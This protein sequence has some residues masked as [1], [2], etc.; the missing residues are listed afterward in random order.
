MED[1]QSHDYFG[2]RAA[3]ERAAAERAADE[4]AAHTHYELAK[5]FDR[6]ARGEAETGH[7]IER[8][9]PGI[10]AKEFRILP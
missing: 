6:L 2:R 8:I 4:R 10:L 5:E 7:E 1:A 9:I 3:E